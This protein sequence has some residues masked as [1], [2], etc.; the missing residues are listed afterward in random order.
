MTLIFAAIGSIHLDVELPDHRDPVLGGLA[1]P[2]RALARTQW[3]RTAPSG[4]G[5]RPPCATRP[6]DR[7][8]TSLGVA[9]GASTMNCTLELMPIRPCSSVVGTSEIDDRFGA[10]TATALSCLSLINGSMVPASEAA[11]VDPAG[12][13]IGHRRRA[14]AIENVRELDAAAAADLLGGQMLDQPVAGAAQ[15]QAVRLALAPFDQ[16]L[17]DRSADW[18]W[19]SPAWS[20]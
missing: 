16:G 1:D 5:R 12:D 11:Q 20:A 9:A 2:T 3:R 19:R 7:S 6:T 15:G 10:I 17:A 18:R 8:I 13:E 4:W 14:T